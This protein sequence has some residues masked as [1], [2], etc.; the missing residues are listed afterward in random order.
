MHVAGYQDDHEVMAIEISKL[1]QL[2]EIVRTGS[3]SRAAE[4]LHITQPAL[5]RSVAEVER[6]FGFK[7]FDRG[8]GGVSPTRIGALFLEDAAALVRDA[9]VM[10]HN[11]RLYSVGDAGRV[12]FGLGPLIA[13]LVLVRLGAEM[14]AE[15]PRLQ[16][17]C[18]IKPAA[19]LLR[20]LL[21]DQIEL[22][23]CA[24]NQIEPTEEI[25][26]RPVGAV[27]IA[28]FVR[29]AHPLAGEPSIQMADLRKFPFACSS[30]LHTH[31]LPGRSG[32]LI[33]D[34]FEILREVVLRG[35]AAWLSSPQMLTADLAAGRI[36]QLPIVDLPIRGSEV[37]V[38][39]LNG[40]ATSPSATAITE[41]V[42]RL[43]PAHETL[44]RA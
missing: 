24:S 6:R 25:E 22:M 20:E 21:D 1:V 14:L 37:A 32:A 27:E 33:C 13:S 29:D 35:D 11:L 4:A 2:L 26:I 41:Y 23:F 38:V 5:S 15:R 30:E 9:H 31:R 28:V 3:F 36:V 8:R 34:N 40:R 43:L 19:V 44:L 42:E 39:K 18:S 16:L 7:L 10:E 12:A 17:R